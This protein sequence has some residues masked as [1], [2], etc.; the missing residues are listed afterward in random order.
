VLLEVVSGEGVGF[1]GQVFGAP[2]LAQ[3]C[4]EITVGEGFRSLEMPLGF[5]QARASGAA[6]PAAPARDVVRSTVV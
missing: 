6:D 4:S 2:R 5:G 1:F 3:G